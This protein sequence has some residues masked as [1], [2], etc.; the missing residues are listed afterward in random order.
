VAGRLTSAVLL[1]AGDD[2]RVH[3]WDVGSWK[4]FAKAQPLQKASCHSV[5]WA[6]WGGTGLGAHPSLLLATGARLAA[7]PFPK[8]GGGIVRFSF[9]QVARNPLRLCSARRLL[10]P[11]VLSWLLPSRLL[12]VLETQLW[13]GWLFHSSSQFIPSCWAPS[14]RVQLAGSPPTP[15]PPPQARRR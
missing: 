11:A 7:G 12:L 13:G 5:G 6:P 8:G 15:P 1:G 4:P 9:G 10:R 2:R 14:T 3:M